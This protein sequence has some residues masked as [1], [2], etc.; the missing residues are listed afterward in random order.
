MMGWQ[1]FVLGEFTYCDVLAIAFLLN[2][3]WD[4]MMTS[5]LVCF[6]TECAKYDIV[7]V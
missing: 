1:I 4:C 5:V 2:C 6:A 3:G 7:D